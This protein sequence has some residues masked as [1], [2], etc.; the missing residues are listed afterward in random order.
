MCAHMYMY[1]HKVLYEEGG[2][3]CFSPPSPSPFPPP[4]RSHIQ[5][6]YTPSLPFPPLQ[7]C[8]SLPL[9][10]PPFLPPSLPP[11]LSFLLLCVPFSSPNLLLPKRQ[12][13]KW[14]Q[15]S[16]SITMETLFPE[17]V[18]NYLTVYYHIRN[19][20]QPSIN[21]CTCTCTYKQVRQ[22]QIEP[23]CVQRSWEWL[24]S[25]EARQLGRDSREICCVC[26][27][28]YSLGSWEWLV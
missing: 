8:V 25:R 14:R 15:I 17:E 11:S 18:G 12:P 2:G 22:Q 10:L 3:T 23:V 13:H 6:M 7:F 16:C 5:Y 20:Y 21:T 27:H 26:V 24:V 4:T 19:K 28:M 1:V 9:S